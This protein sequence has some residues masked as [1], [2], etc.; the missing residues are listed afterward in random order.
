MYVELSDDVWCNIVT[1]YKNIGINIGSAEY[2]VP[3][4]STVRLKLK[5]QPSNRFM[6]EYSIRVGRKMPKISQKDIFFFMCDYI[7]E[8]YTVNMI[9]ITQTVL[10]QRDNYNIKMCL[11]SSEISIIFSSA[12]TVTSINLILN[13]RMFPV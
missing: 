10:L 3:W 1:A 2:Y 6:M 12:N 11:N 7:T 4:S 13:T 8:T 9:R 5:F